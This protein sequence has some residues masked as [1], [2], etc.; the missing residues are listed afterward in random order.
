MLHNLLAG[1][2]HDVQSQW[3]LNEGGGSSVMMY[4]VLAQMISL[5][6]SSSSSSPFG[7]RRLW[8]HIMATSYPEDVHLARD[9]FRSILDDPDQLNMTEIHQLE[10]IRDTINRVFDTDRTAPPMLAKR[11]PVVRRG[12][13][14]GGGG[15]GGIRQPSFYVGQIFQHR[16]Q[17]YVGIIHGWDAECLM[18]RSWMERAY[19]SV[20]DIPAPNQFSLI[21]FTYRNTGHLTRGHRQPFYKVFMLATAGDGHGRHS[22]G[23]R[24]VPEE[25][26]ELIE[27]ETFDLRQVLPDYYPVLGEYFDAYDGLRFVPNAILRAEYPDDGLVTVETEVEVEVEFEVE[28]EMEVGEPLALP[29]DADE[30]S[31]VASHG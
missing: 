2:H 13:G 27:E 10:A 23:T 25:H 28:T 5:D 15:D 4:G 24:Y 20:V 3:S 19:V 14:G 16:V 7:L 22:H 1:V 26:V 9:L 30:E 17:S 21:C 11:R 18:D 6:G 29:V 12:G 8:L 31:V